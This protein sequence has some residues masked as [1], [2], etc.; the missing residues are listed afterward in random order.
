MI[1]NS[2]KSFIDKN[3]SIIC[4]EFNSDFD[5]GLSDNQVTENQLNQLEKS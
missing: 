5:Y 2:Y 4:D 3:L 1:Q